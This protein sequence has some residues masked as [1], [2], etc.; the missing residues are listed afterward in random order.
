MAKRSARKAGKAMTK[1]TAKGKAATKGKTPKPA[2]ESATSERLIEMDEAVKILKTSRST[3]YRWLRSGKIKGMKVGRQW[4]FY[5]EDIQRFLVGE[6]PRIDLPA[7]IKPLIKML[8]DRIKSLDAK[9][10]RNAKD[11]DVQRA[12]GLMIQLGALLGASD[13]HLSTHIRQGHD[14]AIV[15]LRYRVDGVLHETCDVDARLMPAIA[16]QWKLLAACDLHELRQP[17]DGR[18]VVNIDERRLDLRVSFLPAVLG[19]AVTARIINRDIASLMTL[20]HLN[21]NPEDDARLRAAVT[22]PWGLVIMNGPT[23]SGKTTT[24]YAALNEVAKPGVKVMTVEDPVEVLLPWAVQTAISRKDGTTLASLVRAMLRSDPDVLMIG[25]LRDRES[26]SVSLQAALTGHLVMT[27]LH[28]AESAQALKRM[29]EMGEA[30]FVIGDATKLILSQRLVR[31]LCKDCSKK[32]KLSKGEEYQLA[33]VAETDG[34]NWPSL[35][36]TFRAP[37][38]C[39]KCGH[40]GFRGRAAT[41]ETLVMTPEIRTALVADASVDEIRAIAVSQGMT[42]LTADGLRKVAAGT[43]TL[44]EVRRVLAFR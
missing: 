22:A 27:T 32:A 20:D 44:D 7:S 29:A 40:T 31:R 36:R 33:Q 10:M 16:Q 21:Y 23:G 34:L 25:E 26:L 1:K 3:F 38:G 24:L 11:G 18:I 39:A 8:A 28:A 9:P 4:R 12:V 13:I 14:D 2:A 37:V 30:P 42:T 6:E 35:P 41:V 43:T 19:E 5:E 17:Q 15:V